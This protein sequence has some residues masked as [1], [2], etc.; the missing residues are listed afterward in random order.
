MNGWMTIRVELVSGGGMGFDPGPGRV[1]LVGPGHTFGDLADA[2][3][4]HFARWDLSHL[5]D[6]RLADGREI[7]FPDPDSPGTLD[8]KRIS[9]SSALAKGDVFVFVFDFGDHWEHHC[10]VETWTST[11]RTSAEKPLDCRSRFGGGDRSPISTDVDQRTTP[12][13]S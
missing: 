9:V 7:G 11:P 1:L 12:A 13:T 5:H 10:R 2:I 4:L 3:N 6:F 8:Q